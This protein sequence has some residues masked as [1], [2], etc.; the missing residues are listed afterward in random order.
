MAAM[1]GASGAALKSAGVISFT[2]PAS[3]ALTRACTGQCA[4]HR[5]VAGT[6]QGVGSRLSCRHMCRQ[7][8]TFLSV[9]CTSQASEGL[10]IVQGLHG[11]ACGLPGH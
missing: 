8:P 1:A 2:C 5:P 9:L 10:A 6:W 7:N 4:G 11:A 3:A